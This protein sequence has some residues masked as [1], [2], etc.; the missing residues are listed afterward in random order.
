MQHSHRSQDATNNKRQ[1]KAQSMRVYD[2]VSLL[3]DTLHDLTSEISNANASPTQ[4]NNHTKQTSTNQ[5]RSL[6][7]KQKA[8][9]S[10]TSETSI[11][12]TNK[13]A[14]KQNTARHAHRD[15]LDG[16]EAD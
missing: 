2:D 4:A 12:K 16:S 5:P 10:S 7:L 13:K 1:I 11:K 8:T 15:A 6:C 14:S 3:L 9:E